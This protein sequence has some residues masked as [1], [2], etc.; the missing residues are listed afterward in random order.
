M[1]GI[2]SQDGNLWKIHSRYAR[3]GLSAIFAVGLAVLLLGLATAA[4][5]SSDTRLTTQ[6]WTKPFSGTSGALFSNVTSG[7]GVKISVPVQPFFNLTT[8]KATASAKAT[9]KSCGSANSSAES[10]L[11]MGFQSLEFTVSSSGNYHLKATGVLDFRINLT[12]SSGFLQFAGAAYAAGF[13]FTYL[14]DRTNGTVFSPTYSSN[15]S[16]QNT[17]GTEATTIQ[18]TLTA[19]L[20]ATLAAHHEYLFALGFYISASAFVTPGSSTA[21]ASVNMGKSGMHATLSSVILK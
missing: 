17:R 3:R 8:G 13:G 12:A 10:T 6:K 2:S 7:C 15:V 19:Y 5:M 4:P 18:V 1:K 16:G 20:N 14:D 9:A 21:S 11:S